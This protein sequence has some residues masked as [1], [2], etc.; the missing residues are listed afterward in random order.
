[1]LLRLGVAPQDPGVGEALLSQE[2]AHARLKD[3]FVAPVQ[4]D[5]R[6]LN[7]RAA[8]GGESRRPAAVATQ[9]WRRCQRAA[10]RAR[11]RQPTSGAREPSALALHAG[12]EGA[13]SKSQLMRGAGVPAPACSRC[14]GARGRLAV[15]NARGRPWLRNC[16]AAPRRRAWSAARGRA[17]RAPWQGAGLVASVRGV[18]RRRGRNL[19]PQRPGGRVWGKGDSVQEPPA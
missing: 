12:R 5:V 8:A 9:F 17:C 16:R 18:R 2:N 10:G 3:V 13:A 19:R 6:L 1:M 11:H 4:I 14:A 7:N 15:K